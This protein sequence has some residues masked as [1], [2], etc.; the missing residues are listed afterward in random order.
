VEEG[1]I[2]ASPEPKSLPKHRRGGRGRNDKTRMLPLR[3]D[4]RTGREMST[5]HVCKE[6][7]PRCRQGEM[8]KPEEKGAL[9]KGKFTRNR[10]P[11]NREA[12][13]RVGGT[14]E[15]AGTSG[16]IIEGKKEHKVGADRK[17]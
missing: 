6:N 11:S 15:T 14:R 17:Q 12:G 7:P 10:S 13:Y 9:T 16:K 1:K 2:D 8:E 4:S 5:G 3:D